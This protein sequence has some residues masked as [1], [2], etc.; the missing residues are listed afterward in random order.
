MLG[1]G[2]VMKYFTV[3]LALFTAPAFATCQSADAP[4]TG[5]LVQIKARHPAGEQIEGWALLTSDVC[6]SMETMDGEIADIAPR[7][8]HLVFADGKQPRNLWKLAE[9]EV[10]ARGNLMEAHTVWHLGDILMFDTAFEND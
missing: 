10:T 1:A 8:V 6:I 9:D 7:I 4:I 2:G 5:R 3:A